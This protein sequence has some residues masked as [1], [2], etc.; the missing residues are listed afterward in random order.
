MT[1]N[2][3]AIVASIALAAL[4]FFV[5]RSFPSIQQGLS[6]AGY[7]GAFV[8][9]VLYVSSFTSLSAAALLFLMVQ[10]QDLWLAGTVA[11]LG[12]VAG[13]LVVFGLFRSARRLAGA[14]GNEARYS[15]WWSAIEG[16]VPPPWHQFVLMTI[17]AV[18]LL[19]P[20]PNEFADY[21]LARTPKIKARSVLVISYVLNGLGI[22]TILWL[23]RF[24]ARG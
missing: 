20:L 13:D 9:G 1:R 4:S 16:R 23:S 10:S 21:L 18:F 14:Q 22:Y 19:T 6:S 12:A 3:V 7:L 15:G 5:A 24:G 11:T 8:L 2:S 17:V